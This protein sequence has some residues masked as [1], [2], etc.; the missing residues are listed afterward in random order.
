MVAAALIL[1]P[2]E[3]RPITLVRRLTSPS[4]LTLVWAV[5][6]PL[7]THQTN[8]IN[9]I[10]LDRQRLKRARYQGA[11]ETIPEEVTAA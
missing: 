5:L 9:F 1:V 11:E 3:N 6:D 4:D 2:V 10:A 8:G 7:I